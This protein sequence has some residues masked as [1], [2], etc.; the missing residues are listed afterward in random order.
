MPDRIENG[1]MFEASTCKNKSG[2]FILAPFLIN[3]LRLR[4]IEINPRQVNSHTDCQN[5][6][7][8]AILALSTSKNEYIFCRTTCA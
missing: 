4:Q 6:L 1:I 8:G 5:P 3:F 2:L 7:G